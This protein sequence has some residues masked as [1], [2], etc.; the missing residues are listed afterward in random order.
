MSSRGSKLLVSVHMTFF[1]YCILVP[2]SQLSHYR[3]HSFAVSGPRTL[4]QQPFKTYL[5]HHPVSAAISKVNFLA[6]RLAL[7]HHSAFEIAL[8]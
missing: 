1:Q 7:I 2:R 6:E 4:Y 5:H 3:S 8:L